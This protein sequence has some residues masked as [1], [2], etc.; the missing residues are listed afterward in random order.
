MLEAQVRKRLREFDLCI[1]LR[2]QAGETLAI[3][4]PSGAGKTSV[5]GLIAG[6][7]APDEGRIVV[8]ERVLFDS[9]QRVNLPPEKRHLGYVLQ[10]YALFPHLTVLRNIEY[11]MEARGMS[12]D[13]VARRATETMR[14]LGITHLAG[15]R[16]G[17]ISGGER[18]RVALARAIAAS[19]DAL[20]L[21]EPL[22]ALDA[23]TRQMARGDLR[24][25]IRS[26]G[27]PAIFVT[28]DYVDALAFGD[29]ICVIDRGEVVQMGTQEDLLLRPKAKFVAEFMG[30]NFLHGTAQQPEDGLCKVLVDG[31]EVSTTVDQP[32]EV[33]L[34]FSPADVTLS[35]EPPAGSARNV[36]P[37]RVTGLLQL[38]G[39]I[40]IDLDAGFPLV[41]ELTP[42]SVARLH[43]DIGSQVHASFK[44]TAVEAYR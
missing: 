10:E 8:G 38:G 39:R 44:A 14:M 28:H 1:A 12:R 2:V 7:M 30:V 22:A 37:A 43:L 5:L 40:R 31:T 6:L 34:A 27:L 13:E 23:Q 19:G 21:D 3:I 42:D 35:L 11:G 41:A 16:P 17:R 32:G 36:F 18:Q 9:A 4:G 25:V 15:I 26:V 29:Q 20:L 33:F 24:R